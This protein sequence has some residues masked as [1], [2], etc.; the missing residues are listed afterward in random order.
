M[1]YKFVIQPEPDAC[2][3]CIR[4]A[5][6]DGHYN[7]EYKIHIA[8]AN[9]ENVYLMPHS[10]ELIFPERAGEG[11]TGLLHEMCRCKAYVFEGVHEEQVVYQNDSKE[12]RPKIAKDAPIQTEREDIRSDRT[13][14]M[15]YHFPLAEGQD[16]EI[17]QR[18]RMDNMHHHAQFR[19]GNPFATIMSSVI[20]SVINSVFKLFDSNRDSDDR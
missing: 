8:Y 14:P 16:A 5:F 17:R 13:S 15:G 9:Y 1:E 6:V 4:N 12:G 2:N 7:G 18:Y 3:R 19:P 10:G 20:T 11:R